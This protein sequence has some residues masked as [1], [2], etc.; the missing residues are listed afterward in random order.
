V[1]AKLLAQLAD[2]LGTLLVRIGRDLAA[3]KGHG[4]E[5]VREPREARVN[6]SVSMG[7]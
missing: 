5:K 1:C 4:D 6:E 2:I 7:T 3:C